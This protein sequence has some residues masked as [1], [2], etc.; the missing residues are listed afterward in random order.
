ML[1]EELV[2]ETDRE[3]A[4]ISAEETSSNSE[5][6]EKSEENARTDMAAVAQ[7][8]DDMVDKVATQETKQKE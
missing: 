3:N 8:V 6:S 7:I 4:E 1:R 5:E 2:A